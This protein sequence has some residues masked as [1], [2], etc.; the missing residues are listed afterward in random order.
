MDYFKVD[1]FRTFNV[2]SWQGWEFL[3][4]G[5]R[6]Y[7]WKVEP[8]SI[9]RSDLGPNFQAMDSGTSRFCP[10]RRW[11]LGSWTRK[12]KYYA[13]LE[14]EKWS[15]VIFY[16]SQFSRICPY[17][18]LL[19]ACKT[20]SSQISTLGWCN[21]KRVDLREVGSCK[22]KVYQQERLQAVLDGE[23]NMTGY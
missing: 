19:A 6:Q 2:T 16:L 5:T 10:G 12:V 3:L 14:R 15:R 1:I 7:K 23:G 18:E 22:P 21:Y 13:H 9:Q 11:R 20:G 4:W 8:I 17:R